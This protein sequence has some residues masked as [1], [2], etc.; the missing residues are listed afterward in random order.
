MKSEQKI[1]HFKIEECDKIKAKFE[2]ESNEKYIKEQKV[3]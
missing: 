1:K 3:R 2:D